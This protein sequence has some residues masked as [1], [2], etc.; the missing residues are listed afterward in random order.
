MQA[1]GLAGCTVVVTRPAEQSVSLLARLTRDNVNAVSFPAIDIRPLSAQ[2]LAD[3]TRTAISQCDLAIFIS[4]N[5][6]IHGLPAIEGAGGLPAKAQIASVGRGTAAELDKHGIQVDLLP[7]LAANSEAL[8]DEL[9]NTDMAGKH[10]LVIRGKGGRELLADT[11]RSRGASV[12]Y[13]ECYQRCL[14]DSDPA[15]LTRLWEHDGIDAIIVTSADGL[16][17]LYQLV[18]LHDR[19]KLS[20]TPLYV[21]SAAMV[22]LCTDLG[23]KLKPV[24]MNSPTDDDVMAALL[25]NCTAGH[26]AEK[27]NEEGHTNGQ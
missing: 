7:A 19:D 23:Y 6:V 17:N 8:L 16:K 3:S 15:T 20:A 2:L 27:A 5:A 1:N 22:A 18:S 24:L 9:A 11:L 25:A 10:V 4:R 26:R 21:V 14:P 13:L 12:E